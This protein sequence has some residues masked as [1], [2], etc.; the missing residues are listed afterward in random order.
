MRERKLTSA[1][2]WGRRGYGGKGDFDAGKA[3]KKHRG[4]EFVDDGRMWGA[5]ILGDEQALQNLAEKLLDAVRQAQILKQ[6]MWM[7]WNL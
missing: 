3:Y 6:W 7:E 2:S 1:N 5:E 4:G